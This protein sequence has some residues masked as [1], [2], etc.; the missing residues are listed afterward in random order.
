MN[1]DCTLPLLRG[2]ACPSAGTPPI[3]RSKDP[4]NLCRRWVKGGFR[5]HYGSWRA[6]VDAEHDS[7]AWNSGTSTVGAIPNMPSADAFIERMG[8]ARSGMSTA[9]GAVGSAGLMPEGLESQQQ[10]P[11]PG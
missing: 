2:T 9:A 3:R 6:A 1:D 4:A 8:P 10:H 7:G 5:R 11:Y